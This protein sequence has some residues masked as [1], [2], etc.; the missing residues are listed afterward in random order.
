[1]FLHLCR[2]CT[3]P[4]LANNDRAPLNGYAPAGR[5]TTWQVGDPVHDE[6][7][8]RLPVDL[9]PGRYT[10]LLG[11]YPLGN[12]AASAR[13]QAS[14][15]ETEVLD[16]TRVVLFEIEVMKGLYSDRSSSKILVLD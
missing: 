16:G 2:D 4:P 6:R 10:V 3:V 15:R 12:P 13:L 7:T 14:S 5:T 11:V 8:L 1:M 9:Q